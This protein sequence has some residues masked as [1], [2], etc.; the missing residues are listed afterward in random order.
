MGPKVSRWWPPQP[1]ETPLDAP[2][3]INFSNKPPRQ[4]V[5]WC[6][7]RFSVLIPKHVGGLLT[8]KNP[9]SKT[10]PLEPP[11]CFNPWHLTKTLP[12]KR[13]DLQPHNHPKV[14][15][16]VKILKIWL[17]RVVGDFKLNG[18]VKNIEFGWE[19]ANPHP[20]KSNSY[21]LWEAFKFDQFWRIWSIYH[22][23]LMVNILW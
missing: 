11:Q 6:N 20:W 13:R 14:V 18:F 23:S 8:S 5:S 7:C 4:V 21:E 12:T 16:N 2:L 19:M 15:Q 1:Y 3:I 17:S 10:R 9:P 22:S